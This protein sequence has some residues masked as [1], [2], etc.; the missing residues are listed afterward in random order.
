[1]HVIDD[2]RL[3]SALKLSERLDAKEYCA[4]AMHP[5]EPHVP[6]R[7]ELLT[8]RRDCYVATG[9]PLA[10][11]ATADVEQVMICPTAEARLVCW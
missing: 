11:Q 4:P 8:A 9:D 10:I 2:G 3:A 1:M 5:L 7:L 6:W